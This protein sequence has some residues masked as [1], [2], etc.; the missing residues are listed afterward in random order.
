MSDGTKR[1]GFGSMDKDRQREIASKGGRAAH[2]KGT[3][4]RWTAD[5][6]RAAAQKSVERRRLHNAETEK[7]ET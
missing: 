3:A 2:D 6:A 7:T 1:R 5:S 4:H